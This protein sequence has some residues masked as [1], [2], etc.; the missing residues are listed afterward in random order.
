MQMR[1]DMSK[2]KR[3]TALL[4]SNALLFTSIFATPVYAQ[5]KLTAFNGAEGGGMYTLGARAAD[6]IT[7]YHVTNLNSAGTGSFRDAVS[8]G[9]RIIVFDV[10]GTIML[11][12]NLKI[13]SSNLTI[14]GQTATGEGF[15]LQVTATAVFGAAYV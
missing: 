4:L 12:S 14:L 8:Q 9:N 2:A 13:K 6:E 7:V 10:A 1:M 3:A 15:A 11:E 5:D